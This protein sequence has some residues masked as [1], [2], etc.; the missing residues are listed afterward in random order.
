MNDTARMLLARMKLVS[1][2]RLHHLLTFDTPLI[3]DL[4]DRVLR[5]IY[6]T[7][8]LCVVIITVSL[9]LKLFEE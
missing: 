9:T 2:T 7:W 5:N 3:F 8:D 4:C 1:C 6:A